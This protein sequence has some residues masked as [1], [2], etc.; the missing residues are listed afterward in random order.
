MAHEVTAQD[1]NRVYD[2]L[3][4]T[5][6]ELTNVRIELAT[7]A[8]TLTERATTWCKDCQK[9]PVK[10]HLAEAKNT[11]KVIKETVLHEAIRAVI[12]LLILGLMFWLA[13]P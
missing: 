3:N 4:E 10:G 11:R 1:L 2:A 7:I 9:E 5:N 12:Y 6:V 13:T 8:T